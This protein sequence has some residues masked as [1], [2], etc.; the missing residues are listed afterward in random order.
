MG[1][2]APIA[3]ATVGITGIAQD[4]LAERARSNKDNAYDRMFTYLRRSLRIL[5]RAQNNALLTAATTPAIT[6]TRNYPGDIT[7][8]AGGNAD[9]VLQ[10]TDHQGRSMQDLTAAERADSRE[11]NPI[12][13]IVVPATLTITL[14]ADAGVGQALTRTDLSALAA[15]DLAYRFVCGSGWTPGGGAI[16]LAGT[17]GV[18]QINFA[19]AAGLAAGTVSVCTIYLND[20][21]LHIP[22]ELRFVA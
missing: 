11:L 7:L 20:D 1:L 5:P 19:H 6:N 17:E 4:V 15:G 18:I 3:A 21:P 13:I 9:V 12:G 14:D 16:D 10:F 2:R 8:A 22:H